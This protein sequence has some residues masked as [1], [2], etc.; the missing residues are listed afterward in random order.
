MQAEAMAVL[1][2]L[3]FVAEL[4]GQY[5]W[6]ELDSLELVRILQGLHHC[7]WHLHYVVRSI[8]LIM[9]QFSCTITHVMREGNQG[10]DD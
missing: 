6:L 4:H 10:A 2:G 9:E 5:V 7:P 1:S 8:R 3:R